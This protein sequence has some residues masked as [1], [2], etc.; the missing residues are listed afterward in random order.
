MDYKEIAKYLQ[1]N[2]EGLYFSVELTCTYGDTYIDRLVGKQFNFVMWRSIVIT[3]ANMLCICPFP[4]SEYE[5]NILNQVF[6]L[7]E[8]EF[9]HIGSD[10]FDNTKEF[11]KIIGIKN[12][13]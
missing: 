2:I 8:T 10:E 12:K 7:L 6:E 13:G 1:E 11:Y 9:F 3:D 5:E 4:N